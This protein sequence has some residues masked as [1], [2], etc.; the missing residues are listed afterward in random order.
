MQKSRPVSLRKLVLL[1][2]LQLST[3]WDLITTLL[4]ILLI[5]D[6]RNLVAISLA[7][8]GTLIVVA[9]N[10]ST[11]PIWQR[12]QRYSAYGLPLLGLRLVWLMAVAVDLWTSLTCNAWFIGAQRATDSIALPDL[13]GNLSLGQLIIVVF[14][15][16]VSGVSPMLVGYLRDQDIDS[17]LN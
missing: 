1:A 15:T 4:G 10:F 3:V 6:S 8:I 16:V 2:A 7:V 9:F 13:L 17:L 5:L 12:R 14:I 11:R